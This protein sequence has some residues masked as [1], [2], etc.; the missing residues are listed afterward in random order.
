[1][2]EIYRKSFRFAR[3]SWIVLLLLAVLMAVADLLL[4]GKQSSGGTLVVYLF[5]LYYFHRHF[6][7]GETIRS[8][9]VQKPAEGVPPMKAGRFILVSLGVM[10][11][12]LI[13]AVVVAIKF[14]SPDLVEEQA[15]G[16]VMLVFF[17]LYLLSLSLFGTAMPAAV[18]RDARYSLRAGLKTTFPMMWRLL[19]GPGLCN[20]LFFAAIIALAWAETRMAAPLSPTAAFVESTAISLVA[21]F[22]AIVGVATLCHVYRRIV[23]A[24]DGPAALTA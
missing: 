8:F 14:A 13:I 4:D 6:L 15:V 17:P 19:L 9:G 2:I 21:F 20:A 12:P 11:L 3:Q 5:L 18:D 7:F 10:A 16:L 1:M 22:P 24:T 23:P